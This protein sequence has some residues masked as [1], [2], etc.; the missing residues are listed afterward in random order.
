MRIL[1]LFF[2]FVSLTPNVQADGEQRYGVRPT[3]QPTLDPRLPPVIP[4][5][6]VERGGERMKVW[7]SSGPVSSGEAPQAPQPGS[8]GVMVDQRDRNRDFDRR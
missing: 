4:G 2:I 5:E 3:P 8:V 7:S 6:V 1:L